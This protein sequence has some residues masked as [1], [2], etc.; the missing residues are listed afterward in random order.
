MNPLP[1]VVRELR[2]AARNPSTYRFRL[3]FGAGAMAFSCWLVLVGSGL[4]G[5]GA[6]GR[7]LF[8]FLSALG[9]SG[10]LIIGA[11]LTCDCLSRE[12]REGTLGLLYLANLRLA[13]LVL[14][15]FA[16]KTVVPFYALLAL[17]PGLAVTLTLGGVTRG[18]FWRMAIVLFSVLFF[19]V[20]AGLLASTLCERQR[21]AS[22]LAVLI[23]LVEAC[24]PGISSSA[25]NLGPIGWQLTPGGSFL[26]AFDDQYRTASALFWFSIA[27]NLGV[28]SSNLLLALLFLGRIWR[29]VP[30]GAF[31]LVI[32]TPSPARPP[33]FAPDPFLERAG[34]ITWL[35]RRHQTRRPLAWIFPLLL[36]ALWLA[37][38]WDRTPIQAGESLPVMTAVHLFV[39]ISLAMAGCH[40]VAELR[41]HGTLELV[42]V[43]PFTAAEISDGLFAAGQRRALGPLL[44]TAAIEWAIAAR[45]WAGGDGPGALTAAFQPVL[46]LLAAFGFFWVG[47][48]RS[49]VETQWLRAFAHTLA[50]LSVL[51]AVFLLFQ[52]TVFTGAEAA[53]FAAVGGFVTLA[54]HA[55]YLMNARAILRENFRVFATVPFGERPPFVESKWSA[56]NWDEETAMGP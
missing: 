25:L 51:P 46:L 49:L 5:G 27:L 40:A 52:T 12:R 26:L 34:P 8:T 20:S 17:L 36:L 55:F 19:S 43:A 4:P 1:L 41:R 53:A 22:A 35:A 30:D 6:L 38:E 3:L 16:G 21:S 2:V 33:V 44:A 54:N 14:G 29:P 7:A 13:D 10:A 39:G 32:P 31:E 47:L 23:L 50:R 28:A 18:D 37:L 11:L 24:G 9:W 56:M 42:L 15:K 48:W 45:L